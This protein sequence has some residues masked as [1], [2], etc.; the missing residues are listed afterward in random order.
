MVQFFLILL[1]VILFIEIIIISIEKHRNVSDKPLSPKSNV[2]TSETRTPY[3]SGKME[4]TADPEKLN[5]EPIEIPEP[6]EAKKIELNKYIDFLL[7]KI[8]YT[9][10]GDFSLPLELVLQLE[11][12][13][14]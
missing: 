7:E 4:E 6:S 11:K 8:D 14:D 2:H 5:D 9:P 1:I 10:L 12:D 13:C 3:E